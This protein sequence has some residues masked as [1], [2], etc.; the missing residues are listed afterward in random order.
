MMITDKNKKILLLLGIAATFF[1]FAALTKKT[2]A[3]EKSSPESLPEELKKAFDILSEKGY[4]PETN[5]T[6]HKNS[7]VS[8]KT[9]E[10]EQVVINKNLLITIYF[11]G[12]QFPAIQYMDSMFIQSGEVI[13]DDPNL[14]DG[15][16]QIIQ[17]QDYK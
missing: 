13:S 14:V 9:L 2:S 8:F 5:P 12:K 1:V 11:E 4:K 15:V 17:N 6:T 3:P 10:G 16:L 7:F